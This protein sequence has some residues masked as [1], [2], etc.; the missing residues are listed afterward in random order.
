MPGSVLVSIAMA[1]APDLVFLHDD[2]VWMR[3]S[4]GPVGDQIS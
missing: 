3:V 4:L 2:L 1:V